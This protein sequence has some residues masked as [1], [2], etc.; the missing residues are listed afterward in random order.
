MGVDVRAAKFLRAARK[1]GVCFDK[2]LTLGR[3]W[4]MFSGS[5]RREIF[6]SL[7][8]PVPEWAPVLYAD[9]F[10]AALGVKD[11][12]SM[13]VS[14]YEGAQIV[15][16]LNQPIPE[17]LKAQFD[18]VFDGGTTEHVFNYP[19]ALKNQMEMVK[20][21]GRLMMYQAMNNWCG[22]GFYQ[23]SPELLFRCLNEANGF[24]IEHFYA[25]ATGKD[26]YEVVDPETVQ[27]RVELTRGPCPVFL[28]VQARRTGLKVIFEKTPQQSD[29]VAKW[30]SGESAGGKRFGQSFGRHLP[31]PVADRLRRL[32][33]RLLAARD[34]RGTLKYRKH[35]RAV[36]LPG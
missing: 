21:G 3:Q 7:K 22:H 19:Q 15:H 25:H 29:Y 32:K 8:A 33:A 4:L 17:T 14:T 16:D 11:L 2:T 24:K 12:Q 30:Q 1:E 23:A 10:F 26:W 20:V 35:F 18:V 36:K 13:D 5:E 27:E 9:S 6:S 31:E 28:L 34:H